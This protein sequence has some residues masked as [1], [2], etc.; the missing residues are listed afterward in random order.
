MEKFH[1]FHIEFWE[2]L[3]FRFRH[4]KLY[5]GRE[6]KKGWASFGPYTFN[7]SIS[8]ITIASVSN[9]ETNHYERHAVYEDD[10]IEWFC[11]I[12][13]VFS[14]QIQMLRVPPN[15]YIFNRNKD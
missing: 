9:D 2:Q 12:S 8:E 5:E 10:A 1:G 15:K 14:Y 3:G 4:E 7:L 11:Q 6:I 13:P